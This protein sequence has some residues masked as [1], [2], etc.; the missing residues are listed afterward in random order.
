MTDERPPIGVMPKFIWDEKRFEE[1]Q[2]AIMRYADRGFMIS[3]EWIEEY[4]SLIKG[5]R[6]SK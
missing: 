6:D 3:P 1:L 4:N 2:G 5:K